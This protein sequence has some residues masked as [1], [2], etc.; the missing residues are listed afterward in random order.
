LHTDDKDYV[1]KSYDNSTEVKVTISL[2]EHNSG[3]M[4][5]AFTI[6][7]IITT[8]RTTSCSS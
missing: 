2:S 4:M 5:T 1:I 6:T 3:A 7:I 8:L